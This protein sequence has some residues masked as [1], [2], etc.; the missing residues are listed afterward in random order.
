[1]TFW[2]NTSDVIQLFLT[3]C[4]CWHRRLTTTSCYSTDSERPHHCCHL[5][6]GRPSDFMSSNNNLWAWSKSCDPL[7]RF[8]LSYTLAPWAQTTP[9]MASE[10]SVTLLFCT[11]TRLPKAQITLNAK[12]LAKNLNCITCD[13]VNMIFFLQPANTDTILQL[14]RLVS[15]K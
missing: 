10:I 14:C 2:S 7:N 8:Q 3:R 6:S 1:M 9:Q 13:N 11:L 5:W 15:V 12:C 4:D